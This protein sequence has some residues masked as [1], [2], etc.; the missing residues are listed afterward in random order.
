[1]TQIN[2][3]NTTVFHLNIS[4]ALIIHAFLSMFHFFHKELDNILNNISLKQVLHNKKTAHVFE[5]STVFS[6]RELRF[7]IYT[8][9]WLET[10]IS[11]ENIYHQSRKKVSCSQ[12]VD[13]YL[14]VCCVLKRTAYWL[15][16]LTR[17]KKRNWYFKIIRTLKRKGI[18]AFTSL[19]SIYLPFEWSTDF[20]LFLL[21]LFVLTF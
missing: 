14:P 10:G 15:I 21:F 7:L 20:F 5:C 4:I 2:I 8:L 9:L 19:Q 12:I 17:G 3:A 18:W 6:L 11:N 13:L 1:M 16:L